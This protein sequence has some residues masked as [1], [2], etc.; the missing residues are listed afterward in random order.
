[1]IKDWRRAIGTERRKGMWLKS[2]R[3]TP[4]QEVAMLAKKAKLPGPGAYNAKMIS[5][6]KGIF[7]C[8][9]N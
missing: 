2:E 3:L 8:T 6:V 5:K 9:S 4:A 1:M 7:K